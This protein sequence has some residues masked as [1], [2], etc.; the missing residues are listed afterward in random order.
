[1]IEAVAEPGSEKHESTN[2]HIYLRVGWL[3]VFRGDSLLRDDR[4]K[5]EVV[6]IY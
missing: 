1:M 6:T 3:E 2:Q 4:L 5:K